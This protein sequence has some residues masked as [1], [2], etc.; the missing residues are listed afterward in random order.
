MSSNSSFGYWDGLLYNK[1]KAV[2]VPMRWLPGRTRSPE[3]TGCD[4]AHDYP[5]FQKFENVPDAREVRPFNEALQIR[6]GHRGPQSETGV[7]A[8]AARRKHP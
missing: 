7:M 6:K 3:L 1:N 2:I 8:G 4:T 5:G